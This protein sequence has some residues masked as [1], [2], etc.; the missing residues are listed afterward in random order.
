MVLFDLLITPVIERSLGCTTP[1]RHPVMGAR[2]TRNLASLPGREDWVQVRLL[3][4]DGTRWAEPIFGKSS[5]I[6]TMVRADGMIRIPLD[7]SGLE[8]GAWV[9]VRLY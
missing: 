3:E 2:L 9:D 8:Q 7:E 1:L 4:R 6:F 5:L